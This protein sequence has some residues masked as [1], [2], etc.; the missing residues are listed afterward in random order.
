MDFN[1]AEP[2]WYRSHFPYD[3]SSKQNAAL[4]YIKIRLTNIRGLILE[5]SWSFFIES[6]TV[7]WYMAVEETVKGARSSPH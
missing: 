6:N 7:R 2:T 5:L 1:R 4:S 3:S